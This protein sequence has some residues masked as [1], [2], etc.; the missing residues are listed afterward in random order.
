MHIYVAMKF[1]SGLPQL[2]REHRPNWTKRSLSL[3]VRLDSLD[4]AL[5]FFRYYIPSM[6][7][8]T[9]SVDSRN[10]SQNNLIPSFLDWENIPSPTAPLLVAGSVVAMVSLKGNL[11]KVRSKFQAKTRGRGAGAII[12]LA[13]SRT[14]L[15]SNGGR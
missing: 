10:V 3:G 9:E 12:Q 4:S 6:H 13:N 8:L 5:G 14:V 7:K 11:W 2:R 1:A 15:H